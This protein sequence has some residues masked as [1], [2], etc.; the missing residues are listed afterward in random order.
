MRPWEEG[1]EFRT[2]VSLLTILQS[3]ML[4][5]LSLFCLLQPLEV[6]QVPFVSEEPSGYECLI[7]KIHQDSGPKCSM[8]L[9]LFAFSVP[10]P[11]DQYVLPFCAS[12]PLLSLQKIQCPL[13][14]LSLLPQSL[15]FHLSLLKNLI[16]PS[17]IRLSFPLNPIVS[18]TFQLL[19]MA[20]PAFPPLSFLLS[21]S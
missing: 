7:G 4:L 19:L 10:C 20:P 8:L 18:S 15:F 12:S 3:L 11:R 6:Q 14:W 2:L 21:N 9:L 17:L 1:P 16:F 13:L 5:S